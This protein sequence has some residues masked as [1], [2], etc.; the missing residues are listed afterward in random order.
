MIV[1][2]ISNC[3]QQLRGD[4]TKWLIEIDIG[5]YVGKLS[6]RVRD[7][8]WKRVCDNIKTGK[9]I[10]VFSTNNEQGFQIVTHNTGWIPIW[11]EELWLMQKPNLTRQ[12]FTKEVPRS[13][14]S[15]ASIYVNKKPIPNKKKD[16]IVLDIETTGLDIDTDDV[17]EIGMIKIENGVIVDEFYTLVQTAK[18][19]PA[20]IS[21]L[22]GITQEM[23]VQDGI[24]GKTA[25]QRA[26]HFT[27]NRLV[28]GY[29]LDFDINFLD[30]MCEKYNEEKFIYRSKDLLRI[31]KRKICLENYRL[32]TVAEEC[33]IEITKAHRAL[34]DCKI[35]YN[36]ICKLNLF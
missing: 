4:L 17:I 9:A 5:V 16:Y 24:D 31:V 2:S 14:T 8:L 11:S 7:K 36:V 22:T 27:Q 25:I 26:A 32:E 6:A 12:E 29:N 33:G 30:R 21:T 28:L 23:L 3:P 19:V 1:I 13:S 20:L 35:L 34:E 15:R 18:T 10:M